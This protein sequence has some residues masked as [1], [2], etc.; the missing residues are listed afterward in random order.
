MGGGH[1]V[2]KLF[3]ANVGRETSR[4]THAR[5]G[6]LALIQS[7]AFSPIDQPFW[8]VCVCVCVCFRCELVFESLNNFN[9]LHSTHMPVLSCLCSTLLT[10]MHNLFICVHAVEHTPKSNNMLN[11]LSYTYTHTY[12]R[13]GSGSH[14][15]VARHWT[16]SASDCIACLLS[17]ANKQAAVPT[18]LRFVD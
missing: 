1:L 4:K 12:T 3:Y 2:G 13:V 6:A 8:R 16:A 11:S 10:S 14:F 7:Y 15:H 5:S 9:E 18:C 17:T